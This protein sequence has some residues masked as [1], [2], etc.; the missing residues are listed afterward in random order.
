MV[1]V[2]AAMQAIVGMKPGGELSE[3]PR[4]SRLGFIPPRLQEPRPSPALFRD[5]VVETNI[6]RLRMQA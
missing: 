6:A 5:N 1:T 3:T 4:K 2:T